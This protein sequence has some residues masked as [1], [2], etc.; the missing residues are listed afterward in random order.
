M[1]DETIHK[2]NILN[3]AIVNYGADNQID[4]AIEEMAELTKALLKL[5]HARNKPK[6]V[7][8]EDYKKAFENVIEEIADV[9]IRMAQ[10]EI[11]FGELDV[12][13]EAGK[14]LARLERRIKGGEDHEATD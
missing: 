5:R 6:S 10:M 12:A 11:I 7:F 13:R 9:S 4:K 14:K 3:L 2:N 1:S 8:A